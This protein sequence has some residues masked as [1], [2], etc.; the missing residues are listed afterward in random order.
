[1][2]L[3]PRREAAGLAVRRRL[4]ADTR[5]TL[6][7]G[8]G[9]WCRGEGHGVQAVGPQEPSGAGSAGAGLARGHWLPRPPAS[10][11]SAHKEP[12]HASAGKGGPAGAAAAL[13]SP[14]F[15]ETDLCT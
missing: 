10:M 14:L 9:R 3:G 13:C 1:M 2:S 12:C 15:T 5:K 11:S 7:P 6:C 8:A 4:D